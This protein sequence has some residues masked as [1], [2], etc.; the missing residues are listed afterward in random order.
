MKVN[1]AKTKMLCVSDAHSFLAES[2]FMDADG[3]EISSSRETS[4]KILGFHLSSKPG[5][6]MHV[7]VIRKKFRMH[8]WLLL[9]L[10]LYRE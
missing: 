2:Y 8:F 9:R 10:W 5:V 7:W 3:K 1:T 4:I 6:G